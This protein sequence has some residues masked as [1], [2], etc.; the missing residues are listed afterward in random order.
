MC[1]AAAGLLGS[2][3]GRHG[4]VRVGGCGH[5]VLAGRRHWG[6][7]G[8]ALSQHRAPG[9]Q[10]GQPGPGRAPLRRPAQGPP[11][12]SLSFTPPLP[13]LRRGCPSLAAH[14]MTSTVY[15]G[16][17]LALCNRLPKESGPSRRPLW[18]CLLHDCLLRHLACLQQ[19]SHL[20][21][22]AFPVYFLTVT[23]GL[24]GTAQ[25]PIR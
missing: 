8:D 14:G 11:R 20:R 16:R 17:L 24:L 6:L 12:C 13:V 5:R 19:R 15:C 10:P 21:R 18:L 4:G 3:D 9:C 7:S 22:G 25:E 1:S 2:G 23:A